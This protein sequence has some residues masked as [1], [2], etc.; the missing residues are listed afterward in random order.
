MSSAEAI[1][2]AV[3]LARPSVIPVY[4]IT[5]QTKISE[6]LG[7][8][9]YATVDQVELTRNKRKFIDFYKFMATE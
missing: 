6:K 5:P 4:P 9:F 7:K 3:K 8:P 2:E 1:S